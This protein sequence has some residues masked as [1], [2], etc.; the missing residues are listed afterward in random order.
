MGYVPDGNDRKWR[1]FR[2]Q[3]VDRMYLKHGRVGVGYC[4]CRTEKQAFRQLNDE[5]PLEDSEWLSDIINA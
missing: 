1:A 4:Q 5:S 2:D 3:R